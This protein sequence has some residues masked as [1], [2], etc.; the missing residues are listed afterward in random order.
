[1][2]DRRR[3]LVV[4]PTWEL[5]WAEGVLREADVVVERADRPDGDD[6]VGLLVCPDVRV[7]REEL[8]RLPR[9]EAVA[10]NSTGFDNLDVEALAAAGV[11]CSNVSDYCTEE[12]AE[13]T[14]ALVL[15]LLRGLVD[16]DREVRAGVWDVVAHPPRRVAGARLGVVGFG[17]IGQAVARRALALGMDVVGYDAYVPADA[18]RAAGATPVGAL[19]DLLSSSDA[20]TLHLPLTSETRSLIGASALAAMRPGSFLVNCARGALVEHEALGDALRS[21]HLGGAAL[22]VLPTE[23][24]SADEPALSWPRTILNPHAAW[25]SEEAARKPYELAARD[26]MLALTGREPV[27]ALARPVR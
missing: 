17:R 27:H 10:T 26:L 2:P 23:P 4:D 7:G 15:A 3:V 1:V 5:A 20:V 13:H 9:L 12:V 21:G 6:V 16:L 8:E 24:P 18:I 14:I 22:D 25:Y 11:W 19:H